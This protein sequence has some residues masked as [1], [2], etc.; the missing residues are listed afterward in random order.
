MNGGWRLAPW[1]LAA[2]GVVVA[3]ATLAASAARDPEGWPGPGAVIGLAAGVALVLL[4][5][6]ST[7]PWRAFA[8]W[9]GLVV[10]GQ[11]AALQLVRAGNLVRYAHL[12]PLQS[13]GEVAVSTPWVAWLAAQ[14]ALAAAALWPRR[15]GLAA[16]LRRVGGPW[17]WAGT[18][19]VLALGGAT[20]SPSPVDFVG[21]LA[22]AALITATQAATLVA[23]V[24]RAP[25]REL[26]LLAERWAALAPERRRRIAARSVAVAA[27]AVAVASAALCWGVYQRHPHVPDEVVYRI[28]ARFLAHGALALPAPP[29]PAA[30]EVYLM[31][32]D[33]ERWFPSPPP[34][35]PAILALGT[36]AGAD[37]L[38]NPLLAG[39][40]VW[41]AYRFLAALYEPRVALLAALLLAASPWH[42]FLGMSFMTHSATLV[43]ALVAALAARRGRVD[44]AARWSLLAGALVGA[45][46][47]VRP[48]DGAIVAVTLLAIVLTGGGGNRDRLRRLVAYGFGGLLAG[49][50]LLAYN[51]ALVGDLLRL[52]INEYLDQR[53]APGANAYG[54]GA[55]RGMGWPLDPNPGHSVL[56][57]WINADLNAFA[58]NVELFGWSI[59]SLGLAAL[60]AF[61]A[62]WRPAD[63]A[64][65]AA[66]A[67]VF[68]AHFFYYFSGGPDFGA[69]YWFL[70]IVPLAA[71]TARGAFVVAERLGGTARLDPRP[72]VAVGL[73][74]LAA[75]TTFVPWRA[76]DKYRHYRG[77]RPDLPRLALAHGFGRSLVL[78][79]GAEMPD[80][81]SAAVYN[82]LDWDT[83][84]P[85]Y[86]WDR[87]PEVRAAVLAAF[88]DRPVWT[89]D[90]P[91]LTGD[92][93]V[94]TGGPIPADRLLRRTT[95]D[96]A[97]AGGAP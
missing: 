33:G 43:L 27:V 82:P 34:G 80:Y 85:I 46:G 22:T 75:A 42:L 23:A 48:L 31:H 59:G 13:L 37:W 94:V 60:F 83:D 72:L 96:E 44:G 5:L 8:A 45:V 18:A 14:G 50:A 62:R 84:V 7:P 68:A 57:G 53:F 66:A 77:M 47:L 2:A 25:R 90:G 17:S 67:I 70:M 24:A 54:F 86:A 79:R 16:A 89:V 9:A 51:Q 32:V 69:R 30:F 36:R 97:V 55:D 6:G 3:V 49:A 56:D 61:S 40:A 10:L 29:V 12:P 78:V 11:A 87:S 76:V 95:T 71:L 4:A 58:V 91:T 41:L 28:H 73:L 92:G 35:W 74:A 20:V 38:V 26:E 88:A 63:V 65:L 21:E 52:P 1:T 19:S 15:R 39:L 93:F 64:L 81:A